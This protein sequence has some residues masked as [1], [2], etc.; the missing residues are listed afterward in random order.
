MR[1]GNTSNIKLTCNCY[2]VYNNDKK[3]ITNNSVE[4]SPRQKYNL[5]LNIPKI[6]HLRVSLFLL[7]LP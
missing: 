6:L 3:E 2:K 5:S 1:G 4:I 7:I